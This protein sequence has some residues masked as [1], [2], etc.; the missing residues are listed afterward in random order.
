MAVL[1]PFKAYRPAP[2]LASKV[3]A[4]FDVTV[5]EIFFEGEQENNS[6]KVELVPKSCTLM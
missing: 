3:A 4:L 1:K 5:D 6:S 2:E